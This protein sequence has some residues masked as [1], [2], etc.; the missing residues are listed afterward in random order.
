MSLVSSDEYLAPQLVRPNDAL[1]GSVS[2]EANSMKRSTR[3][4]AMRLIVVVINV[5]SLM[6][7]S[8][9]TRIELVHTLYSY[10]GSFRKKF[11]VI[12]RTGEESRLR[13]LLSCKLL[14]PRGMLNELFNSRFLVLPDI[15][16]LS[17]TDIH[18]FVAR[19]HA[20]NRLDV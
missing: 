2:R 17:L 13:R 8:T 18:R 1:P 5:E 14:E 10:S 9:F 11:R 16:H 12:R 20:V 15:L 19:S 7:R 3:H 4:S 6:S